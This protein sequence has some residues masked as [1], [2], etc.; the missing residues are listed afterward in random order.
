MIGF[1]YIP[2]AVAS[3]CIDLDRFTCKAVMSDKDKETIV[4]F[5]SVEKEADGRFR[6][7]LVDARYVDALQKQATPPRARVAV[8]GSPDELSSRTDIRIVDAAFRPP[9]VYRGELFNSFN[10]FLALEEALGIGGQV[11]AAT[12][13]V[14][15]PATS[16]EAAPNRLRALLA[17]LLN[18]ISEDALRQTLLVDFVRTLTWQLEDMVDSMALAVKLGANKDLIRRVIRATDD[19]AAL[20][21]RKAYVLA[22]R[23]A[24]VDKVAKAVGANQDEF[25]FL[26]DVL[27]PN[28]VREFLPLAPEVAALVKKWEAKKAQRLAIDAVRVK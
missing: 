1:A 8:F 23:G 12:E 6:V 22:C 21:L 26:C 13:P 18:S 4:E 24:T 10:A 5:G 16:V 25:R 17:D 27:P 2:S 20:A 15:P 7:L 3:V 11:T 19:R 14:P 9:V 28:E